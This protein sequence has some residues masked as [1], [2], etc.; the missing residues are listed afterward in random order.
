MFTALAS[1]N[2][3][4]WASGGDVPPPTADP[5]Q[6]AAGDTGSRTG[7]A[8]EATAVV[9]ESQRTTSDAHE[10]LNAPELGGESAKQDVTAAVEHLDSLVNHGG[11]VEIVDLDRPAFASKVEAPADENRGVADEQSLRFDGRRQDLR[12]AYQSIEDANKANAT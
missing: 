1:T 7:A 9:G 12:G 6:F 10:G 3:Q 8:E 5:S 4:G 11:D 2:V